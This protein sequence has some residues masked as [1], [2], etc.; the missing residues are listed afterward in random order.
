MKTKFLAIGLL[1]AS[2]STSL[3][4][5][6]VTQEQY[7]KTLTTKIGNFIEDITSRTNDLLFNKKHKDGVETYVK[8]NKKSLLQLNTVV[9][10]PHKAEM[11]KNTTD[12]LYHKALTLVD[13]IMSIL[14]DEM[15]Q[16]SCVMDNKKNWKNKAGKQTGKSLAEAIKK[17]Y[18][19]SKAKYKTKAGNKTKIESLLEEL[20]EVLKDLNLMSASDEIK[21]KLSKADSLYD[22]FN[23][24]DKEG[25]Q[26]ELIIIL[27]KKMKKK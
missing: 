19:K 20:E 3:T 27:N 2:A 10:I 4:A 17:H 15:T 26:A 9:I 14:H 8:N 7:V 11:V 6:T 5:V 24:P 23:G 12:A 21:N 18:Q 13:E 22:K 1:L 16:L 25:V